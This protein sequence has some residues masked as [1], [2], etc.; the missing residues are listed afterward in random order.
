M[1]WL[2]FKRKGENNIRSKLH[3]RLS[4]RPDREMWEMSLFQCP[5]VNGHDY[6]LTI[7]P[8]P[9]T[10]TQ[11]ISIILSCRCCLGIPEHLTAIMTPVQC[12]R[13]QPPP[14][15]SIMNIGLDVTRHGVHG[16]LQVIRPWKPANEKTRCESLKVVQNA[17]VRT[18]VDQKSF[19]Y[20]VTVG[21]VKEVTVKSIGTYRVSVH[22]RTQSF[23]SLWAVT[24]F[25]LPWLRAWL[26]T[27]WFHSPRNTKHAS[28]EYAP[29]TQSG[30]FRLVFYK[31][32]RTRSYWLS[33]PFTYRICIVVPVTV[34]LF[35]TP[36]TK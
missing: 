2:D 21:N 5:A 3:F 9:L 11:R 18:K 13:T 26:A 24:N 32:R 14:T 6:M 31:E 22:Y 15:T 20:I 23:L 10:F 28:G 1:E 19:T 8:F 34:A 7:F 36:K 33:K 30:S 16:R 35:W 29:L 4:S 12:I 25:L 17:K 27:F